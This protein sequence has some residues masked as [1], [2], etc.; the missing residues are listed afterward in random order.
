LLLSW[1]LPQ[2]LWKPLRRAVPALRLSRSRDSM[3][4]FT[5]VLL[6]HLKLFDV[7]SVKSLE[8][9]KMGKF[10]GKNHGKNHLE[11][12]ADQNSPS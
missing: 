4:G 11:N 10:T 5:H 12:L 3:A 6:N 8:F 1:E 7:S 9:P 2:N